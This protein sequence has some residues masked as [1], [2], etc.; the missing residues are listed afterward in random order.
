MTD[1][2][3]LMIEISLRLG[4]I[5]AVIEASLAEPPLEVEGSVQ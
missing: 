3:L 2:R 4:A 1:Q 5:V